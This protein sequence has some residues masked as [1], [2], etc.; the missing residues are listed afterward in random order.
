[1]ATGYSGIPA[2]Q[3][4]C[5]IQTDDLVVCGRPSGASSSIEP[6][7]VDP[8]IHY[9]PR[10]FDPA[11]P[12]G[13]KWLYEVSPA[14]LPAPRT[15]VPPVGAGVAVALYYSQARS[16][17]VELLDW[18]KPRALVPSVKG[19]EKVGHRC[20]GIVYH[21]RDEKELNRE[22]GGVRS[23]AGVRSSGV[24]QE[25]SGRPEAAGRGSPGGAEPGGETRLWGGSGASRP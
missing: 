16:R 18:P 2:F 8:L 6:D 9:S 5:Q 21:R 25:A 19:G 23:G 17:A 3:S 20:G 11:P 22:P 15:M 12:S 4:A 7:G 1:M 14:V 13:V 24:S 10:P